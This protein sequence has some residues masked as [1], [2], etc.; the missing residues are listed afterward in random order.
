M[1]VGIAI[2]FSKL[3]LNLKSDLSIKS[4]KTL[5]VRIMQG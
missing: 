1:K 2:G 4:G 3:L 5:Y